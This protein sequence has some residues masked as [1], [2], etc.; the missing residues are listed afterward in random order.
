VRAP[1]N[2]VVD[3]LRLRGIDL[4]ALPEAVQIG[5]RLRESDALSYLTPS[6]DG[7]GYRVL[8]AGPAMLAAVQRPDGSFGAVHQTWLDP[9]VV[10]GRSHE[11]SQLAGS[12][13]GRL[14]LPPDAEGKE[15][16]GKKVLGSKKGGAI[17]LFTPRSGPAGA[18]APSEPT[19]LGTPSR[20]PTSA[21]RLVM[22]EG[23]ETTRTALAHAFEPETAYWAGVDLGNMAGRAA[24]DA[25]GHILH[26][27][28]DL[29]D[30]ECFLPPD[31]V[32]ELV[33]LSDSDDPRSH[34]EEKVIRGLRRA[35]AWRQHG[36]N[37]PPLTCSYMPPLGDGRDLNDL[38]RVR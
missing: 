6:E 38:V 7:R 9:S 2:P 5:I 4:L 22:G 24:R 8:C 33:Y 26:E 18:A 30:V 28:P 21:R 23:I 19:A 29:D 36:G 1:G 37:V 13:N 15:R 20:L 3:Y 27:I 25:D 32:E 11:G 17:R 34:T 14:V 16:P 10:G 31:W 12:P 35:L